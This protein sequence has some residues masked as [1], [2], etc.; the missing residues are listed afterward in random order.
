MMPSK[1]EPGDPP[2]NDYCDLHRD[3]LR[4]CRVCRAQH[5]IDRA[6]EAAER[7]ADEMREEPYDYR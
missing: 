4:P 5:L 7:K 6:E 2:D 1:Y 3:Y